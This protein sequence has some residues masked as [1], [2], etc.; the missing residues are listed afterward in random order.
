MKIY[1]FSDESKLSGAI[2]WFDYTHKFTGVSAQ[3]YPI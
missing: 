2:A 1:S 3:A